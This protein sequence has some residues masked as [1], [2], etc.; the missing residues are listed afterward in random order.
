MMKKVFDTLWFI[1]AFIMIFGIDISAQ[2]IEFEKTEHDFGMVPSILGPV[3]YS[4]K[5]KNVGDKPLVVTTVTSTCG[6][7]SPGWTKQ[8]VK[9]GET[10]E[11]SA[12]YTSTTSISP[13][14]KKVTVRTNGTPNTISLGIKGVVT[15]NINS[16][17]PDSVGKLMIKDKRDLFFPQVVSS[18][19]SP[20]QTIEV[21]NLTNKDTISL[22]FEN[23]PKYLIIDSISV[24]NPKRRAYINVSVDGTKIKNLGYNTGEFTVKSGSAGEKIKVSYVASETIEVRDNQPVCEVENLVVDLGAKSGKES[25]IPES[26]EIKNT[27]GSDLIIKNF[28]TDNANFVPASKKALKIKPGKTGIVKY[29]AKNLPKG[30]NTANIYLITNAPETPVLHY[31]VK[32]TVEN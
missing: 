4:F 30:D 5:F 19:T 32:L 24:V 28:T 23:V 6:C 15:N 9:P 8:P 14:N 17:F 13:F 27:G 2:E 16:A 25:K 11:V 20:I 10:G 18:Q 21:A 1:L 29:S 12:T 26:L 3:T 7:T 31:T 22:S